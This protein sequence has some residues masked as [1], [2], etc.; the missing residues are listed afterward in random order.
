MFDK[1]FLSPAQWATFALAAACFGGLTQPAASQ[2]AVAD[3]YKGK[4][5]DMIIGYSPGGTYDLYARLVARHLGD[6]IPGKPTIVPRNMPGGGSRTAATY[7]YQVAKQDG[8]VLA[9]ADQS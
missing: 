3:F 9:T 6:H 7:I 1:R 2:D 5:L 4:Q 8:T